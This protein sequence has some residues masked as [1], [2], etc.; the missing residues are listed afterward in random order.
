MYQLQNLKDIHNSICILGVSLVSCIGMYQLQNL[1]DIHNKSDTK[2]PRF[3]IS[4]NTM[5][6]TTPQSYSISR[7]CA[8]LFS[9]SLRK[10]QIIFADADYLLYL[11]TVNI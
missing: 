1:K 2:Y 7:T 6:K 3:S 9:K 5:S 10:M 4:K 11:C 8:S